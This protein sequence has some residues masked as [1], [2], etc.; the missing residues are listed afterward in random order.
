MIGQQGG[1]ARHSA[2][3]CSVRV[4]EGGAAE[5][6]RPTNR[7]LVSTQPRGEWPAD[8]QTLALDTYDSARGLN[9]VRSV[10]PRVLERERCGAA[11]TFCHVLLPSSGHEL[12]WFQ[13][14]RWRM[15]GL[16]I[17]GSVVNTCM[18]RAA[19]TA[20]PSNAYTRGIGKPFARSP[21]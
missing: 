12:Q 17:I 8:E 16:R 14:A 9:A 11:L 20:C 21:P 3:A 18:V 4:M 15:R 7:T 10:G 2:G 5:W 13:L 19:I 6:P 1:Y